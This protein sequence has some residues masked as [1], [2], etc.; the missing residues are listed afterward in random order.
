MAFDNPIIKDLFSKLE[1]KSRSNVLWRYTAEFIDDNNKIIP[2]HNV[3][4]FKLVCNFIE[5][6][7]PVFWLNVQVTRSIKLQVLGINRR[8]LRVRFRRTPTTLAGTIESSVTTYVTMYQAFIRNP[9]DE[10]IEARPNTVTNTGMDDVYALEELDIQLVENGLFE[11]REYNAG[12][13]YRNVKFDQLLA[14][15]MSRPIQALSDSGKIGYDVTVAPIHNTNIEYQLAIPENTKLIDLPSYL[16]KNSGIY[17]QGMANFLMNGHWYIYPPYKL[18]NFPNTKNRLTIINVPKNELLGINK[19]FYIESGNVVIFATGDSLHLDNI[20]NELD[21]EG[22]G[23]RLTKTGDR[24]DHN[25]VTDKGVTTLNPGN[26]IELSVD[27]RVGGVNRMKPSSDGFSNNP[28]N[29]AS[30]VASKICGKLVV[31]WEYSDPFLLMPG[32]PARIIYR[33]NNTLY[34]TLGTL[35]AFE[36]T[37][38]TPQKLVTDNKYITHTQLSFLISPTLGGFK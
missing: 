12:K 4:G 3:L 29:A 10:K 31:Q 26:V 33:V 28:W 24:L 23:I 27:N 37:V 17:Q 18:D 16:Q 20:E 30:N 15:A 11:F 32:M 8:M 2:I 22:N 13:V 38:Y 19:S 25:T 6:I 9:R 14:G 1:T 21:K 5:N 36:S 35:A 7:A 34:S